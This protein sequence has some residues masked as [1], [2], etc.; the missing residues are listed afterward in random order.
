MAART[1][2]PRHQD[3]IRTKIQTSQLIN[4]L[5]N[6]A[7]GKDDSEMTTTRMKAIEILLKKTLPDLSA[8]ELTGPDGDPIE[9]SLTVKLVSTDK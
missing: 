6:H 5:E 3:E 1:L 4:V 7:F 9:H 8:T 2:R